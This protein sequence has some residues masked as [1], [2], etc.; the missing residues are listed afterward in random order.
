MTSGNRPS[1]FVTLDGMA[2]AGKTTTVRL[3]GPYLRNLGYHV[4]TTAE[5]TKNALGTLARQHVDLYRK[6]TLA[7]LIAAD[8]YHHLETEI[9][10]RLREG[11][12]VVC[13]RYL[14]SSYALQQLDGV[15]LGFVDA[16]NSRA[17]RPDLA[18]LL[19][20]DPAVA[21]SRIATR[22]AHDRFQSGISASEAEAKM[23]RTA[24]SYLS[25]LGTPAVLTIDTTSQRPHQVMEKIAQRIAEFGQN[26]RDQRA[27]A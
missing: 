8:R 11:A 16:L 5:P 27:T 20:A 21:A 17:R 25:R 18:V 14:A 19:I 7:C 12:V 2:G 1:L 26:S 23:Y 9:K 6:E 15:P 24:A 3:L 13:D 22:G 4:H 10:P